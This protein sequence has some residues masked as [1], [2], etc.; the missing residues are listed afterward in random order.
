MSCRVEVS[1]VFECSF[2]RTQ[3]ENGVADPG[4]GGEPRCPQCF[5]SATRPVT[6]EEVGDFVVTRGT[7]FR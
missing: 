2:C 7:R 5:L 4:H 1:E 3:F 6:P